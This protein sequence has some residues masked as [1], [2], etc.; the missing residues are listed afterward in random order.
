MDW[1]VPFSIAADDCF[2][3]EDHTRG[4][5]KVENAAEH[6]EWMCQDG[7]MSW[8]AEGMKSAFAGE[9]T[10]NGRRYLVRPEDCFGY[11]DNELAETAVMEKYLPKQLS[12]EEVTGNEYLRAEKSEFNIQYFCASNRYNAKFRCTTRREYLTSSPASTAPGCTGIFVVW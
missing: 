2:L 11:A 9:V 6:S 1:G 4:H 5:V 12:A 7:E 8:H 10:W 3:T